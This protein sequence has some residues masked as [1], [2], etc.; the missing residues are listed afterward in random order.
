VWHIESDT[1]GI[2]FAEKAAKNAIFVHA[3]YASE[4]HLYIRC[5]QVDVYRCEAYFDG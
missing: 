4:V 2:V 1:S 3:R 5:G